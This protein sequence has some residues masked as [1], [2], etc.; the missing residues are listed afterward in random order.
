MNNISKDAFSLLKINPFS[1][2]SLTEN[3]ENNDENNDKTIITEGFSSGGSVVGL[4]FMVLSFYA[5]YINLKCNCGDA[6]HFFAYS[7]LICCCPLCTIPYL[8]Y[9]RLGNKCG[10]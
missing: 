4:I 2:I 5:L 6:M 7:L 9:Q 3:Y 10:V 1:I 8:I